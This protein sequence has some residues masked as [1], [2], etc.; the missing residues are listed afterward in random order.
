M[1]TWGERGADFFFQSN[2]YLRNLPDDL[3]INVS[4][5]PLRTVSLKYFLLYKSTIGLI[6]PI[7]CSPT[8]KFGQD[9]PLKI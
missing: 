6:T 2:S 8:K 5:V 7:P 4:N 9:I 1:A 3:P